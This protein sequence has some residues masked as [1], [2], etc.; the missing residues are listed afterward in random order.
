MK[1]LL[2]ALI[3]LLAIADRAIAD[4]V[5]LSVVSVDISG[6]ETIIGTVLVG[7]GVLWA[8]RKTIKLMNR[9]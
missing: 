8:I 9:S 7:C 6:V 5:D 1:K 3:A 2:I 4:P